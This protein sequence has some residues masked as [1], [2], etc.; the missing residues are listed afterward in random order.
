MPRKYRRKLGSR[1]YANYS[2][3]MIAEALSEIRSK[4]LTQRQ[5]SI[6]YNIPRST[7]KNKLKGAHPGD[8]GGPTVFTKEEEATFKSYVVTAS[9][10]GFPVDTFDLRCIVKGYADRKGIK[11]RQFKNNLPGKEWISS[12]LKRHKDLTVRFPAI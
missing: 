1:S 2:Q 6:K 8:A 10:Y 4:A 7:L 12:F 3:E 11:I 5:A 9:A